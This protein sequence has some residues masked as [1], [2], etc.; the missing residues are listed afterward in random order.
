METASVFLRTTCETYRETGFL[1]TFPTIF[2]VYSYLLAIYTSIQQ[3]KKQAFDR[4]LG[5]L[6]A[7][8]GQQHSAHLHIAARKKQ[9]A[10]FCAK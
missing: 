3:D 5:G 2:T 6:L 4:P 9:K 1:G 10:Q 7:F 8:V